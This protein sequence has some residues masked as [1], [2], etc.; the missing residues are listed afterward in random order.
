MVEVIT[1]LAEY[2]S[3]IE[4]FCRSIDKV[5][6]SGDTNCTHQRKIAMIFS[7]ILSKFERTYSD[8]ETRLLGNNYQI[9]IPTKK[10][11]LGL[12]NLDAFVDDFF[13]LTM[14]SINRAVHVGYQEC[15][16]LLLNLFR[17][18]ALR[19]VRLRILFRVNQN[20]NIA[21]RSLSMMNSII[22]CVFF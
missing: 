6:A 1:R 14:S 3:Y 13:F 7:R 22:K 5:S 16:I 9:L 2:R 21:L 4:E 17:E 10:G 19:H 20:V 8:L 18:A 15:T 11:I 12:K